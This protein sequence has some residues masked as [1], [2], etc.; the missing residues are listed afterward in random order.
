MGE[1]PGLLQVDS[2][3]PNV[4]LL[5]SADRRRGGCARCVRR[6]LRGEVAAGPQVAI[7]FHNGSFG[8]TT[9]V[10][11]KSRCGGKGK[12]GHQGKLPSRRASRG[13][14]SGIATRGAASCRVTLCFRA[15][16]RW[17]RPIPACA[18]REAPALDAGPAVDRPSSAG[19]IGFAA[20]GEKRAAWPPSWEGN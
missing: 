19:V 14:D 13:R 4:R 18:G 3:A 7:G 10:S 9:P 2:T 17:R 12:P 15:Q 20:V 16:V 11:Q 6:L 1:F 8:Q 5:R